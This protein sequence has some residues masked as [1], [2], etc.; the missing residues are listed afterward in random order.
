MTRLETAAAVA[1]V[2]GNREES[3]GLDS[4]ARD[5]NVNE[6]IER[7]VADDGESTG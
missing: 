4:A 6:S 2:R 7:R 3:E 5:V 1:E